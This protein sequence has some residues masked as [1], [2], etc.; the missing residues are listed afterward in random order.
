MEKNILI[1]IGGSGLKVIEATLIALMSGF[2]PSNMADNLTICCIDIDIHNPKMADIQTL[3][4]KYNDMSRTL[5]YQ[6]HVRINENC[7]FI[8]VGGVAE[9]NLRQILDGGRTDTA[10]PIAN[11]I[12][13]QSQKDLILEDGTKGDAQLG[14]YLIARNIA[15]NNEFD[16]LIDA[17]DA[18]AGNNVRV[19]ITG[20]IFGGSGSSG[21]PTVYKALR[22][23]IRSFTA[24]N[25]MGDNKMGLVLMLPYFQYGTV[26]DDTYAVQTNEHALRSKVA[27]QYYAH[28]LTGNYKPEYTSYIG[29]DGR[30]MKLI[31]YTNDGEVVVDHHG[32]MKLVYKDPSVGGVTQ[33]NPAMPE[34]LYAA[35]SCLH[36]L[37][38]DGDAH[39]EY[40]VA[41]N[42]DSFSVHRMPYSAQF[43]RK[44][45]AFN[46][47]AMVYDYYF[48]RRIYDPDNYMREMLA[49]PLQHYYLTAKHFIDTSI[50]QGSPVFKPFDECIKIITNWFNHMCYNSTSPNVD[51]LD[52]SNTFVG[53]EPV[54]NRIPYNIK[55]HGRGSHPVFHY[56]ISE[57]Q[58]RIPGDAQG[59][60]RDMRFIK[61]LYEVCESSF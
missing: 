12:F 46:R 4:S 6:G 32:A 57:M 54:V 25:T 2:R 28:E 22:N 56:I 23:K 29:G 21:M 61:N 47:F 48:R 20:S 50:W 55:A 34:E 40:V 5:G 27:L 11:A 10:G 9:P 43:A 26:S 36:F 60:Q 53:L 1:G 15:S 3:V 45:Q 44:F 41:E 19:C 16:V 30:A 52:S 18:T 59:V 42:V 38:G 35:L 37:S 13:K 49:S 33:N 14:S 31:P 24:A 17:G 39:P 58:R 8:N 51:K 7:R